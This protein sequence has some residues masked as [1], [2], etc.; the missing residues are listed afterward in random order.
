MKIKSGEAEISTQRQ[1]IKVSRLLTEI[2]RYYIIDSEYYVVSSGQKNAMRTE[3][4]IFGPSGFFRKADILLLL[5]FLL[6]GIASVLLPRL[7]ADEADTVVISVDG[8]EYGRY[9]LGVDREISVD[10]EYGHNTVSIRS[11][12]VAVTESDCPS[13]DCERFGSISLPSQSILCLPHRLLV[14]ISGQTE[15][16]TVIY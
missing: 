15:I 6:L 10:S 3:T 7:T 2:V 11:S 8:T 16:D 1:A 4:K 9:P 13:H 12:S 5:V 14:R